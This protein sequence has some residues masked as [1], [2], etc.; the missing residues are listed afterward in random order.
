MLS[1]STFPSLEATPYNNDRQPR[2]LSL[3]CIY[4]SY[5]LFSYGQLHVDSLAFCCCNKI[6]LPTA[7]KEEEVCFCLW[8]R[9]LDSIVP[10][11]VWLGERST[12]LADHILIQVQEAETVR[13]RAKLQA[14]KTNP[15][16]HT[17][18]CKAAPPK[19]FSKWPKQ[20]HQLGTKTS[21]TRACE[22]IS[23]SNHHSTERSLFVV[24]FVASFLPLLRN[25]EVKST[26]KKEG[27]ASTHSW[28]VF[29]C[30][31]AADHRSTQM[32]LKLTHIGREAVREREEGT[33][34][35]I[36]PLRL[37]TKRP[38]FVLDSTFLSF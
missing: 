33:R 2:P 20:H 23:H 30:G 8:F 1:F 27:F 35:P 32:N 10:R 21:N 29:A 31:E 38:D 37:H 9:R 6:Q 13:G 36:Y 17:S 16:G 18:P 12:K 28:A 14:I 19:V 22:E 3:E 25:A 4:S 34:T 11:K 24:K 5:W 15:Q 26:Y 7:T